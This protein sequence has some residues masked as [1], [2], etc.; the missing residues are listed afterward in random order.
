MA[1]QRRNSKQREVVLEELR[2]MKTHPT[3]AELHDVVRERL[4]RISLGTVYRNLE[5]LAG[6]G[7][8]RKL[9]HGGGR[10]RF[11]GDLEQHLHVVCV[12]CGGVEDVAGT[13]A[14]VNANDLATPDGY[15]IFGLRVEFSGLCPDCARR[16][17]QEKIDQLRKNLQN[18]H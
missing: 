14:D 9:E 1:K 3:A 16:V 6:G 10:A 11:D 18:N 15:Q 4:P 2:N 17:S 8:V 12:A 7:L 5:L 13:P